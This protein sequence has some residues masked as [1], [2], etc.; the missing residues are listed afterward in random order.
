[1]PEIC[2]VKIITDNLTHL[3]RQKTL[4]TLAITAKS[5]YY[6]KSPDGF[7][8]FQSMLPTQI[9]RINQHG[10]FIWW[11]FE[12][13]WIIWQ[14]LG[15]TGGWFINDTK[16]N[17]GVHLTTI[18]GIKLHYI[19]TRRF[20]TLKFLNPNIAQSETSKKLKSLGPDILSTPHITAADYITRFRKY[21]ARHPDH[22]IGSLLMEQ[23][24]MAGV[25]NYLRSEILYAARINPHNTVSSLTDIQLTRLYNKTYEL[26]SASYRAGGANISHYSD[27]THVTSPSLALV[28]NPTSNTPANTSHSFE[29]RVYGLKKTAGGLAIKKEK[30][31]KETQH[32]Y[33][34]PELQL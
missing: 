20:G 11:E 12:N 19:D 21:S 25:G 34:C 26:A 28:P 18:D 13:G 6:N 24:I 14:T 9:I 3:L 10:K 29:M 32:I 22:V 30:L 17:S 15:L 7:N 16:H 23:N 31:G 2:E 1:M 8:E 5:R 33:W 27:I 4:T